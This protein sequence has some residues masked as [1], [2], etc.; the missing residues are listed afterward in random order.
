MQFVIMKFYDHDKN[1]SVHFTTFEVVSVH[2]SV[3]F[4]PSIDMWTSCL[5]KSTLV[6][7]AL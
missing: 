6:T 3:V 4:E 5:S 1:S 2:T 7:A